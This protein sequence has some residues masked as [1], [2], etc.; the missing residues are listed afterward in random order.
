MFELQ[1]SIINGLTAG[2]EHFTFDPDDEDGLEWG[3]AVSIVLFR[4]LILKYRAD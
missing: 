1:M 2:I 3:I 4:F